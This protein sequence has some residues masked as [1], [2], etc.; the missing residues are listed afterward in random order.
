MAI[1][2]PDGSIQMSDGR[3]LYANSIILAQDLIELLPLFSPPPAW[4]FISG[5]GGAPAAP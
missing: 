4:P 5:G 2:L 1:R 3:I